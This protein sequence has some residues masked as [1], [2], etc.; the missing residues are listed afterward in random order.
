MLS[1]LFFGAGI[2]HFTH[3]TELVKIT[4]LP[5]AYWI[6]WLTGI[7]EFAFAIFLLLPKYQR[8]TGILLSVFALA[9]LPANINMALNDIPMFGSHVAAWGAWLRVFMQFPL[10]L[11]IL[12]ATGF[13]Q[14]QTTAHTTA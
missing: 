3:D 12:W 11:W 7:M 13:W 8:M 2:L 10:I 9:V 1:A 4:P 6:V 14:T 5:Y